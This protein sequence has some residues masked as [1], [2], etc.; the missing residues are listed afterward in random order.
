MSNGCFTKKILYFVVIIAGLFMGLLVVGVYHLQAQGPPT[1]HVTNLA[2]G[3]DENA[4]QVV[5]IS[6]TDLC[7]LLEVAVGDDCAEGL[8]FIMGTRRFGIVDGGGGGVP[9]GISEALVTTAAGIVYTLTRQP[10]TRRGGQLEE[11]VVAD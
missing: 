8:Q 11:C 4:F 5:A 7:V 6:S 1:T 2:C 3:M 9:S 10:T